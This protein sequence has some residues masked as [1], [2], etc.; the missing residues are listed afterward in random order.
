MMTEHPVPSTERP[1]SVEKPGAEDHQHNDQDT[2]DP[3]MTR[4][5][6]VDSSKASPAPV[7]SPLHHDTFLLPE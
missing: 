5:E 2:G 1:L 4:Q 7:E 3:E 6:I